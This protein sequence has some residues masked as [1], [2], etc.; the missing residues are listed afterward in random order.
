M[1]EGGRA[2]PTPAIESELWQRLADYK[3]GPTDAA[4]TFAQRLARENR[5]SA[6]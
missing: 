5:W 2:L 3:I 6:D 4:F 1:G